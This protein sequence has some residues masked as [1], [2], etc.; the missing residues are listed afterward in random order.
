M[1]YYRIGLTYI[2]LGTIAIAGGGLSVTRGWN[3]LGRNSQRKNLIRAV[4]QEWLVNNIDLEQSFLKGEVY[5]TE[6]GEKA[7]IK[8]FP[9]LRTSALNGVLSSGLWNFG[10]IKER[11]FLL[12]IVN[13]EGPLRTANT[14]FAL[15]NDNLLRITG[16]KEKITYAEDYKKQTL[17]APWF[18]DLVKQHKEMR[19]FLISEYKWAFAEQISE[20]TQEK[21]PQKPFPK[22]KTPLP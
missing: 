2:I 8:L 11:K 18:E 16:L 14:I 17:T 13:Y 22:S 21:S 10:N 15:F 7:G 9:T 4:A 1:D 20:Q 19:K 3:L 5:W 12:T 6:K